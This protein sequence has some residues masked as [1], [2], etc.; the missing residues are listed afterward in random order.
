MFTRVSN[1]Q[2][3]Y[4]VQMEGFPLNLNGIALRA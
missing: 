1:A 4:C 2:G 3:V